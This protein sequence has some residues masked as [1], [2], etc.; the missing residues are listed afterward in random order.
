MQLGNKQQAFAKPQAPKQETLAP[1]GG[2]EEYASKIM[3]AHALMLQAV[4]LLE[5]G[6]AAELRAV[7]PDVYGAVCNTR[8]TLHNALI[9]LEPVVAEQ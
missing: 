7:R 1:T 9:C 3:K 8:S 4:A 2:L 6:R 5:D